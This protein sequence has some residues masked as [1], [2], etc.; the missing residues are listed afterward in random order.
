M[1]DLIERI[2][3]SR[4]TLRW[5][6]VILT[7]TAVSFLCVDAASAADKGRLFSAG[8]LYFIPAILMVLLFPWGTTATW[9]SAGILVVFLSFLPDNKRSWELVAVFL[10][11]AFNSTFWA[12]WSRGY[13]LLGFQHQ[14]ALDEVWE[15]TNNLQTDYAKTQTAFQ[16][17]QIKVQRYW[18]LNELARNLAMIFKIQDVISLLI[19][20]ISKTF[21]APGAI[22]TLLLFDSSIG[23]SLHAVRYGIDTDPETRHRRDRLSPEEPFNAWVASQMRVLFIHDVYSD[24]RFQGGSSQENQVRSLVAAPLLAGSEV[25]GLVRIESPEPAAFKQDD[26]RLLSNFA[27]LGTVAIEHSALYR[28]TIELA[29]TDG[30]TGLYVQRY[31]KERVKDEV[32]RAQEYKLPLCLMMI[33]VDNFKSYNDRYGHLVGDQVLKNIARVLKETVRAVDLVARYGGEEFSILL[34][35]TQWEGARNVAERIRRSVEEVKIPVGDQMT[36]VTVSIG[37]A[38]LIPSAGAVEGFIDLADQA[39]YQAKA[40]GKNCVVRAQGGSS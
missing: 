10:A 9:V 27:D 5:A 31:Y 24:F 35:K 15:N 17:N 37:I 36:G 14:K 12:R 20:T 8:L 7:F 39:L 30:L 32:L 6:A 22:Y 4:L 1:N 23:K 25:L 26:A 34:P 3:S 40:Q 13:N 18:A 2:R 11:I 29:I 21:M 16:S 28:Q 19:E 33:D 38:D